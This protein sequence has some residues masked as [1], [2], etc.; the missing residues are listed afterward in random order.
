MALLRFM[1]CGGTFQRPVRR[2]YQARSLDPE[3]DRESA[4]RWP[5]L[6]LRACLHQCRRRCFRQPLVIAGDGTVRNQLFRE[7]EVT[8]VLYPHRIQN[9][10]EVVAFMLDHARMEAVHRAVDRLAVLVETG[11]TKAGDAGNNATHAGHGQA[12]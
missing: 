8:E 4:F 9:T 10:V 2:Y 7:A 11:I 5:Q 3:P 12:A 6:S 1:E